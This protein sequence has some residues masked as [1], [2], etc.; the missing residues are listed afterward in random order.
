MSALGRWVSGI[1]AAVIAGLILFFIIG[2]G[3]PPSNGG[4]ENGP[5]TGTE[6]SISED[7]PDLTITQAFVE[8]VANPGSCNGS[9]LCLVVEVANEGTVDAVG[10]QDG[11]G[12]LDFDPQPWA[13]YTLSG[14]VPAGSSVT[15]RS[16]FGNLEP[17]LPATF[18]LFCEVDAVGG[19]AE[20]DES[21]NT[22]ERTVTLS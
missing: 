17:W 15:F 16:G 14:D 4:D 3:D 20:S 7:L 18:T 9:E 19:I 22:Y 21:N 13:S 2:D 6:P 5:A 10:L 1:A 8:R 12:A 11:C